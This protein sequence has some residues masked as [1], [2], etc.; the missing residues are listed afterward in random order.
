MRAC[1]YVRSAEGANA[2]LP[3][4]LFSPFI[5]TSEI[6]DG[7]EKKARGKMFLSCFLSDDRA[8]VINLGGSF[9]LHLL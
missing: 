4:K 9:A 6:D 3:R 5:R 2:E 7:K 1:V 8:D